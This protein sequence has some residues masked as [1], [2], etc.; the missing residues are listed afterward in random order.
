MWD[1]TL[2]LFTNEF[3]C[4]FGDY[5]VNISPQSFIFWFNPKFDIWALA[6]IFHLDI[7]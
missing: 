5:T 6:A 7:L 2:K 1:T 3:Q 4:I